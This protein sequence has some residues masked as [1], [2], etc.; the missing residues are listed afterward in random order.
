[1]IP[2]PAG[3]ARTRERAR[4]VIV[5]IHQRELR[6]KK[7]LEL[8]ALERDEAV[9]R[10]TAL[11]RIT[12]SKAEEGDL[13]ASLTA[14]LRIFLE[15]A[16]HADSAAIFLR[17]GS[18]LVVSATT[19]AIEGEESHASR[20]V[21][22]VRRRG[23]ARRAPALREPRVD[24]RAA[25]SLPGPWGE[26]RCVF[27]AP[28]AATAT[29]SASSGSASLRS[30]QLSEFEQRLLVATAARAASAVAQRNL[31]ASRREREA[32][33]ERERITRAEAEHAVR[34]RD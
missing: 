14:L 8:R 3:A 16:D 9:R 4:A 19:G 30:D 15:A 7:D 20:R 32:L 29:S 2:K 17:E 24:R 28:S 10:L 1:M 33:L 23:G 5:R 26:A 27:G 21:R 34:A 22:R 13:S 31:A 11:E 6:L 25:P 18:T 12:T